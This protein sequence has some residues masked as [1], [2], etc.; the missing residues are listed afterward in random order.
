L[1]QWLATGISR[2]RWVAVRAAAFAVVLATVVL[3]AGLAAAGGAIL[4]GGTLPAGPLVGASTALAGL[5]LACFGVALL[6]GQVVASRQAAVALAGVCL[7]ILHLLNSLPRGSGQ[8]PTSRW[9]SPF[10]WYERSDP[11]LAGGQLD[12]PATLALAAFGVLLAAAARRP[13]PAGPGPPAP[14]EPVGC[15][16]PCAGAF[17]QPCVAAPAPGRVV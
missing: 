16:A 5:R 12:L 8:V 14:A 3:L 13:G 4:A 2:G 7:G 15:P 17:R 10:Y 1:E 11:L 6:A 9:L